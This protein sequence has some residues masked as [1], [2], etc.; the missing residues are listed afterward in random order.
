M[1]SEHLELQQIEK[2]VKQFLLETPT[3][4]DGLRVILQYPRL[5]TD[6]VE[7]LFDSLINN[8]RQEGNKKLIQLFSDRQLLL[9]AV[10]HSFSEIPAKLSLIK[11]RMPV[12]LQKMTTSLQ[13]WLQAASL[14]ESV[15]ILHDHPELLAQAI[16][17]FFEEL[18][19]QIRKS[20]EERF[21]LVLRTHLA[22]LREVRSQL[23]DHDDLKQAL[24]QAIIK[25][26]WSP[27]VKS[28]PI[29]F[30]A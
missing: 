4:E 24:N 13:I 5:L 1:N 18:I 3:P 30:R 29:T 17:T 12:E 20:G 27:I 26:G 14:E 11:E 7:N 10:R 15:S 28:E 6:F 2:A 16:E 8:A 22:F 21:V 23:T 25:L 19:E 9:R